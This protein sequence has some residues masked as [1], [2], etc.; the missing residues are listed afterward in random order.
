MTVTST[1]PDPAGAMA[2]ICVEL[3]TVTLVA[4]AVPNLTLVAPARLVP[5][6]VTL[7]PPPVGPEAGLIPVTAGEPTPYGE[8]LTEA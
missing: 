1:V 3:T 8:E 4:L 6:I 2:V 5:V 7:V